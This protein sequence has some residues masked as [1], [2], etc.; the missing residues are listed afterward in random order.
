[1]EFPDEFSSVGQNTL[2]VPHPPIVEVPYVNWLMMMMMMMMMMRSEECGGTSEEEG[3]EEG[4]DEKENT[5]R[6]I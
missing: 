1:M 3:G 2:A 6:K 5:D 4:E